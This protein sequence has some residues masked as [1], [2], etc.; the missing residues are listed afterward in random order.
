MPLTTRSSQVLETHLVGQ[1]LV[2]RLIGPSILDDR[3]MR[4]VYDGL[5][6]LH[7]EGG[8]DK[9]VLNLGS[10]T[11]LSSALLAKLLKFH[12]RLKQAGGRLALCEVHTDVWEVFEITHLTKVFQVYP[13]EWEALLS[14]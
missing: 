9:I 14:F 11:R 12:M 6:S 1:A 10:V 8:H 5:N 7:D 2:A 13:S 3:E 4:L